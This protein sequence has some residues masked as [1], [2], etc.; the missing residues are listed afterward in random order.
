MV[1]A[2]G[3]SLVKALGTSIDTIKQ[4][5]EG[6]WVIIG[7]EKAYSLP[8]IP[9]AEENGGKYIS[10]FEP[11]YHSFTEICICGE[12]CLAMQL[13]NKI[14]E[15]RKGDVCIIF[16]GVIHN[17]L[18]RQK[19]EYTAIWITIDF[20][21]AVVHLSGRGKETPFAIYE[22]HFFKP[23]YEYIRGIDNIRTEL[24]RKNVYYE[25]LIK[26]G[27]LKLFIAAY[28]ELHNS[29]KG[30]LDGGVWKEGIILE[31]QKYIKDNYSKHIRLI[32]VSQIVCISSNYLNAIFKTATGK[33]IVQYHED[34]R[35]EMAKS[36]L[37]HS[38]D[39]INNI[40][41][42]LGYYDQYHFSKIF[43]KFTGLS[44]LQYR[45]QEVDFTSK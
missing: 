10:I 39:N 15:L 41:L 18:S 8:G 5:Y 34:Y 12:G 21:R 2:Y 22:G 9:I 19:D 36:L 20:N 32:D 40:S 42:E 35:I 13:D 31:V 38:Q 14:V 1:E 23:D 27:L 29:S 44:P 17:E 3:I 25:D 37:K 43:K 28:R 33:T 7:E 16:P 4:A 30:K 6:N 24:E 26:S 11:E 45:K